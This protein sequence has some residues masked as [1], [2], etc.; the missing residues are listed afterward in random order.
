[1]DAAKYFYRNVIYSKS[2][3]TVAIVD[4][5]NP[6]KAKETL[7]PWLGMVLQLAD[8]QHTIQELVD[9]L[10]TRYGG[11]PPANLE[12]TVHS[13]VERLAES[14]LI[15]LTDVKTD[16]PYYLSM[17]VEMMDIEKA[18]QLLAIDRADVN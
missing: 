3:T 5:H 6:E 16:L 8:G 11:N 13:V 1:M 15:M 9:L 10:S 18:K 4:I 17:P 12:E 14:K 2:G 7:E